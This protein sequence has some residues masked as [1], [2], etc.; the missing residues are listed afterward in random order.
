MVITSVGINSRDS[1]VAL[2]FTAC[3]TVDAV[4]RVDRA[5]VIKEARL[6]KD[7]LVWVQTSDPKE[8]LVCHTGPSV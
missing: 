1:K 6:L 2:D 3:V 7:N 8:L 4:E 5:L